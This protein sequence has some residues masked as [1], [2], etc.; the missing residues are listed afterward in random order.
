MSEKF[1]KFAIVSMEG[2]GGIYAIDRTE[3]VL[4]RIFSFDN[5]PDYVSN[6]L[7]RIVGDGGKVGFANEDGEIVIH[8][9]F[10]FAGPF[11]AETGYAVVNVGGKEVRY[12]KEERTSLVGGKWGAINKKGEWIIQPTYKSGYSNGLITKKGVW[13]DITQGGKLIEYRRLKTR[14]Q[15]K[16]RKR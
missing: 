3:K 14:R 5:G 1:V 10:A 9:Q 15:Q 8:P 12:E 11:S 4:F 7:L 2:V 6:G 13:M 16:T